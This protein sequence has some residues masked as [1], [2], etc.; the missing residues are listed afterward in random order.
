M[1]KFK[2]PERLERVAALPT[3]AVG[4]LD[5]KL[6]QRDIAAKLAAERVSC[7]SLSAIIAPRGPCASPTWPEEKT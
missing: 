1:A 6:L 4:K 7:A 3:T 5:K 2:W